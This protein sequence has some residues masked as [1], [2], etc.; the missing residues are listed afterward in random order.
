MTIKVTYKRTY[1][2]SMRIVKNGD[3]HISA[4]IGFSREQIEKFIEEQAQWIKEAR[5]RNDEKQRQRAQFYNQ[6]SLKTKA[7]T[8]EAYSKLKLKIEPIVEKYSKVM[9]V[10]P[11]HIL[12]KPMIS[13]WGYCN[14]GNR[15]I[16]FSMYVLLLPEICIEHIVVHELCHLLEPSHNARFHSLMDKFFPSWRTARKITRITMN[17]VNTL[18]K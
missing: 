2:L 11:S 17:T 1:R 15:S 16:C 7:Q 12:Y 9:K 10:N 18:N 8:D 14:I 5:K 6:M 3:V 4:P 13:R